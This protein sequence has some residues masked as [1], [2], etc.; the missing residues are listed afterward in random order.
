MCR[1]LQR[2]G[3]PKL[4]SPSTC[5]GQA[6]GQASERLTCL[7]THVVELLGRQIVPEEFPFAFLI[8]SKVRE[9]VNETW[10]RQGFLALEAIVAT[11][12]PL[13]PTHV[14]HWKTWACAPRLI[15]RLCE[16]GKAWVCHHRHPPDVTIRDGC[17]AEHNIVGRN[18]KDQLKF[19]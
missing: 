17:I 4:G 8:V 11:V 18:V 9:T 15:C 1:G 7:T 6:L 2:S 10:N 3:A 12:V 16:E 14:T 5:C 19:V 13:Q